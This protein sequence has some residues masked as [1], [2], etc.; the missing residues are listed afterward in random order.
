[1][2]RAIILP[3]AFGTILLMMIVGI[4]LYSKFLNLL[5]NEHL[6]E[7][8]RLGSPQLLANNSIKNNLRI[9][10][11]LKNREYSKFND[12]QLTKVSI[13][14]WIYSIIY[15]LVFVVVL[16]LFLVNLHS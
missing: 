5:K 3:V 2:V 14:L 4:F 12:L 16:V 11:F 9:L 6:E 13:Y 15:L 7:W 10:V 1:M 8:K